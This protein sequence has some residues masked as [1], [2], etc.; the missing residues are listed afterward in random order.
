MKKTK[1]IILTMLIQFSVQAEDIKA[2]VG[3][4]LIDGFKDEPI[5]NSV[6]IIRGDKISAVGKM[7]QIEIP[8]NA[9]IISTE[10]MTV[11]PGLW[12][13]HVHLMINGHADYGH[14]TAPIQIVL[15]KKS[16]QPQRTN[17]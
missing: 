7:G 1:L 16:C 6:V 17:Y 4:M 5:Q 2:L 3:G 15:K 14:C 13:M 9:E 8:K 11:M 12:D 10:G